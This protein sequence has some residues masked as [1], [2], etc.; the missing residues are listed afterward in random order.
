M[1]Q[2]IDLVI[3]H[4]H[5]P[6]GWCSAYIAKEKY[7]NAKLWGASHGTPIPIEQVKGKHV[8][9]VDFSYKRDVL[10]ELKAAA[11][12]MVVLDHHKTAEADLQG[13]DFCVFDMDRSGAGLTFDTLYSGH[14]RPWWVNYTEA[15]DLWRLDSLIYVREVS[16]FLMALPQTLE[17]WDQMTSNTVLQEAV[18][19]GRAIRMHIDHYIEKVND[20]V[21][22]GTL[23]GYRT[24]VINASYPNISDVLNESCK[25]YEI[26]LGWFETSTGNMQFSLRSTG[27]LDVS[28]IAK[29]FGGGGH[30]N[31]AGFQ[32]S[33][34]EGR[35]LIDSILN[36]T[37][38]R[39]AEK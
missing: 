14:T 8:L 32:L 5:C 1:T 34:P 17:A 35:M 11:A 9:M 12:S 18:D 6:D 29:Q 23:S 2:N 33:I 25:K 10:L 7:P 15:R 27:D 28:D 36:R 26:G 3:Y 24:A 22:K 20:H 38:V 31:A 30:K 16:A 13:L 39:L 21:Q 19:R 4:A 37:Y